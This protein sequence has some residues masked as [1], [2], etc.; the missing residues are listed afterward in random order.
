VGFRIPVTRTES[1]DVSAVKR[2]EVH[3]VPSLAGVL[4]VYTGAREIPS[5]TALPM[6]R[7]RR[8]CHYSANAPAARLETDG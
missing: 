6:K 1:L 7:K 4:Q 8:A 2:L 5:A 3:G